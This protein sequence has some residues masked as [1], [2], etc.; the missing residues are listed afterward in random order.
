MS[1]THKVSIVLAL[2]V[3]T[4]LGVSLIRGWPPLASAAGQAQSLESDTLFF[5][6]GP[7][8]SIQR[9]AAS[10]P[11]RLAEQA[12]SAAIES[13][14]INAA[15]C[16]IFG[17]HDS[18]NGR[19]IAVDVGCEARSHTLLLEVVTGQTRSAEP[20]PWN[21]SF[22]LN[23]APDGDSFLLRV[24]PIGDDLILLVNARSGRFEQ[25]EVPPFTY[26]VA[27]SPDGKRVLYA[28]S[29]GL[30]FGSE[31]WLMDRNGRNREQIIHDPAHVIAYPRWSPTGEAIAY[32]RMPDSNVPFT[33]GELVLADGNGRNE[34]VVAPADAGHGYPPVWSP[35]GQ[36]VAFVVRENPEESAADVAAPYLESNVCLADAASG[37]ARTVT[38]FEGALTDGP[39]WSPDGVWLA[40]SSD[41]GGVADVWLVEVTSGEVQQV[42]RSANARCPV[43]LAG[44]ER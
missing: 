31:V 19:W 12:T 34:R 5:I 21:D 16:D 44:R 1:K 29:R 15:M 14:P 22:F 23:W 39:A 36:Q 42:T 38:R 2:A 27:F 7:Q 10:E 28:V 3:L 43:W 11:R 41:A 40:F 4:A 37:S 30:G 26:D 6:S 32:V 17:L 18:P 20:E 24:D 35:D 8:P 9:V 33:V 25:M 13:I